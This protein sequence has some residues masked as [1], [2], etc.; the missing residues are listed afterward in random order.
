MVSKDKFGGRER[1][2]KGLLGKR[3]LSGEGRCS[4]RGDTWKIEIKERGGKIN[5]IDHG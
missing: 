1:R 2:N 3:F 4:K 5:T